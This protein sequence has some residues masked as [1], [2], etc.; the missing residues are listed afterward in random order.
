MHI[1]LVNRWYPPQS[2]GGVAMHNYYS[3]RAYV[4]LGHNVTVIAEGPS[5]DMSSD[6][7][8]GQINVR[9]VQQI[10]SS[11]RL[12]QVP[13]LGHYIRPL[14]QLYYSAA[15][16]RATKRLEGPLR[17]D[18]V[19]FADVNAEGF[20]WRRQLGQL[21]VV[22][23]QTP[24]F[25][26]RRYH[27]DSE[28]PFDTSI[29]SWCEKVVIRRADLLVAPTVDMARTIADACHLP[30]SR[31][32]VVP[33]ALDTKEFS[34]P[35]PRHRYGGDDDQDVVILYVGRLHRAKGVVLL[36]DAI[37]R[38]LDKVSNAK[39]V[40]VGPDRSNVHGHSTRDDMEDRL[41][42]YVHDGRVIF[43][44][45]IGHSDLLRAYKQS[46]ISV[47]PSILYES[48]SYTCAQ[49]MACGL[50][51]V[52]SRVGGIPETVGDTGLLVDPG[53]LDQ[54]VHALVSLSR[55]NSLRM[56]LGQQARQKAVRDFSSKPVAKCNVDAFHKALK[57]KR[58]SI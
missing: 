1:C 29:I 28:M 9:R 30:L 25:V 20:F 6:R 51:V 56:K 2:F 21:M 11:H 13:V 40:F 24:T 44:G 10:P 36:A 55:D 15:V 27:S 49:A 34:P 42:R 33:D 31:F 47:V 39:F 16:C 38:V 4:S 41:R 8:D 32:I 37:P 43:R 22:R 12:R 14:R 45:K 58:A 26:L 18:V 7:A 48:F 54:L 3:T 17:P 19:E 50:P 23:C 53:S 35:S 5:E 46:D 52:A 57:D